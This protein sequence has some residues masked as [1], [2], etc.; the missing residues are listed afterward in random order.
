MMKATRT[1]IV[2]QAVGVFAALLILGAGAAE[3]RFPEK[4]ITIIVP[5]A[6]GG[7]SGVMAQTMAKPMS[8]ELKQPVVVIY[9][10]GATGVTGTLE[11]ERSAPD[12]YTLASY[13][14]S[15][16]LTQYTSPNPTSMANIVPISEVM[17]SSATLS[18]NAAQP[19]KTLQEFIDYA[20]AN[21]RKVRSA[22][23]GKGGS[24]HIFA[25]AFD[26]A[27]G[28]KQNHV[29]FA[30]SNPAIAAVA[31]GHIE[32]TCNP[33][34][35]VQPMVKGGK[36]RILAVAADERHYLFPDVPT[37]KELNVNL[38]IDNWVG[39]VAPRGTP[40][41]IVD[42]LDKAIERSL[43]KPEVIKAFNDI[44]NIVLYR[45][46]KRFAEWLKGHDAHLRTLTETLGLRVTPKK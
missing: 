7:A 46:Q 22:N 29:P 9:K 43:K 45:D 28:T 32:A 23:S 41:E 15:Q 11:L 16:A 25:E 34:G 3:A 24:N 5:W 44:G 40:A 21:P 39:I 17:T 4:P 20:K 2:F 30:G 13:S 27:A 1:G 12:G 36:L 10:P 31:G 42:I 33:V 8:E 19:W 26:A 35:D 37:M 14:I 38:V 18:V 6:P